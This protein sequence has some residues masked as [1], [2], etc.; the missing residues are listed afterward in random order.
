M[1]LEWAQAQ[2]CIHY[3]LLTCS[4]ACRKSLLP[5]PLC[6]RQ[7]V[8]ENWWP[9]AHLKKFH[10]TEV[11]SILNAHFCF[12][13]DR[14]SPLFWV[15]PMTDICSFWVLWATKKLIIILLYLFWGISRWLSQEWN[16]VPV[17]E[18]GSR[19]GRPAVLE[20]LPVCL[21]RVEKHFWCGAHP[22]RWE[23]DCSTLNNMTQRW[24]KVLVVNK[25]KF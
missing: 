10:E 9:V 8:V 5:S 18:T 16:N 17:A 4:N 13:M 21:C 1:E 23:E 22:V 15:H 2:T 6:S 14:F 11:S 3:P 24:S 19:G 25:R 20:T 7:M 12:V